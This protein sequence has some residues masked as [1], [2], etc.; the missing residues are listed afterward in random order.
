MSDDSV[1]LP[2]FAPDEKVCG[3]CKL[4]TP[5]SVDARG[6]V[7]PCRLAAHRGHFPPSA[8]VCDYYAPRG[9][10]TPAVQA[11]T[12]TRSR[13]VRNI[14]PTVVRRQRDPNEQIDLEGVSMTREELMDLFREA[15]G[16]VNAP[17]LAGKWEGG[18]VTLVPANR[19]LQS[20]ELPIDSLFHK[21]VMIRDRLR[22]LEQ[23]INGNAK[24][25]DGDKVEL[26]HY[27]TRCYGSLTTFNVLFRDKNDQ[28]TG[29]KGAGED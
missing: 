7:G 20:K 25:S 29:Q 8:P 26:Q 4:W 9:Q 27:I 21:V 3:N 22:T 16:D 17:P 6:W 13:A 2:T 19:E 14:A 23:K 24:L 1:P 15:A 10:A 12:E 11:R 5:H 28:F 18:M